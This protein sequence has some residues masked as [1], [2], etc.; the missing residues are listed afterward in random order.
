MSGPAVNPYQASLAPQAVEPPGPTRKPGV[1]LWAMFA[2]GLGS[3]VNLWAPFSRSLFQNLREAATLGMLTFGAALVGWVWAY[4]SDRRPLLGSRRA[5][6]LVLGCT[7][8]VMTWAAAPF[9]PESRGW[10]SAIEV[11]LSVGSAISGA[12]LNGAL[13][14]LARRYRA[15]ARFAAARVGTPYIV[16]L[17]GQPLFSMLF[18]R[19][20]GWTAAVGAALALS[21]GLAAILSEESAVTPNELSDEGGPAVSLFRSKTFWG[22]LAFIAGVRLFGGVESNFLLMGLLR[23]HLAKPSSGAAVIAAF[24]ALGA[25][26]VFVLCSRRLSTGTLLRMSL[27]VQAVGFASWLRMAQGD[28]VGT[29]VRSVADA[30]V[31]MGL[32]TLAFRA[33]PRGREALGYALLFPLPTLLSAMLSPLALRLGGPATAGAAIGMS[34]LMALAVALL[35]RAIRQ[36]RDGALPAIPSAASPPSP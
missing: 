18:E 16:M 34:V 20:L 30:W 15:P 26:A 35:P 5:G 14:E 33:V 22:A 1:W 28:A 8:A 7:I 24:A 6:H 32:T 29:V 12:A 17:L 11:A 36:G 19:P 10:W 23:E 25:A 31:M 4:V 13:V 3:P 21:V 2:L 27:L 9:V